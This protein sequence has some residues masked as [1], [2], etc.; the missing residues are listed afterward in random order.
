MSP[1]DINE[2]FLTLI[3]SFAK[4]N[5]QIFDFRDIPIYFVII[6]SFFKKFRMSQLFTFSR[7][8]LE[9]KIYSQNEY[10]LRKSELQRF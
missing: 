9:V 5:G 4:I 3:K 6:N 8:I 2:P 7:H 10:R 1:Q